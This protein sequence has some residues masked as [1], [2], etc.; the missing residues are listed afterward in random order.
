MTYSLKGRRVLV[1]AGS[2]GLGAVICERFG[3][4]GAHVMVNYV[5]NE[6]KAQEVVTKVKAHGV[7]SFVVQGDASSEA[8]NI[9]IVRETVEKLGGLDIIVANAGWTRFSAFGDLNALLID[10]WNK[11]WAVNV[12]SH[13]HL[14]RAAQPNFAANPDGGSYII[15]SSIAGTTQSGS[16]LPYSVTKAAGIQLMKCLASTQGPKIRINAVLPGQLLTDWGMQ[17]DEA[18][19]EAEKKEATLKHETYLDDCANVYISI[20]ENTSLTGQAIT[21]DSGLTLAWSSRS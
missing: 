13:V 19:I 20:A 2:R 10:D 21:V 1:T 4:K 14:L 18:T 15:T 11:C 7:E 16:S 5:A 8:D 9:R 6:S 17:F 12:L 3:E